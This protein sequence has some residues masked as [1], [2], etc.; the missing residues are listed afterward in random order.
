MKF[1]ML[2]LKVVLYNC[3]TLVAASRLHEVASACNADILILTGTRV[4]ELN[5]RTYHIDYLDN[6]YTCVQF[7]WT[8]APLTNKCAGVA[9]VLGRR[10]KPR[11]IVRIAAPPHAVQGRAGLIHVKSGSTD[12]TVVAG[13]PPPTV[14]DNLS[15]AAG[16]AVNVTMDWV[17][18][19]IQN[20]SSRTLPILGLDNVGLD[21]IVH[22]EGEV[23]QYVG[24]FN[25]CERAQAGGVR[26]AEMLNDFEIVCTYDLRQSC[27]SHLLPLRGR[28]QDY[29]GSAAFAEFTKVDHQRFGR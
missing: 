10:I 21:G 28:P 8:R 16:K 24:E 9:V 7:G 25:L 26:A 23:T 27:W 11:H 14:D 3:L 4:R 29:T 19:E 12:L 22:T 6:G 5:G 13:Y 2:L 17:Y 20:V 18:G 1:W 15:S